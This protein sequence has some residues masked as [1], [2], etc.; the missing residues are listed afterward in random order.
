MTSTTYLHYCDWQWRYG[1]IPA[2]KR[3]FLLGY[4]NK[5]VMDLSISGTVLHF[6][7]ITSI[8]ETAQAKTH[9]YLR[10][11]DPSFVLSFFVL[12]FHSSETRRFLP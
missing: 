9:L 3:V 4:G 12:G 5:D 10:E 1:L 6:D 7:G 11:T 8:D 2:S